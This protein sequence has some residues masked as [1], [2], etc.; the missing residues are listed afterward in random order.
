MRGARRV[1]ALAFVAAVV[2]PTCALGDEVGGGEIDLYPARKEGQLE[3]P[4]APK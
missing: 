1:M 2:V 3:E 4:P